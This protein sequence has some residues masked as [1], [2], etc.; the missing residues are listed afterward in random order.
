MSKIALLLAACLALPLAGPVQAHSMD[1][2]KAA[3]ITKLRCDR[4][5]KMAA[6]C[7]PL[8][9]EAHHACD[10]EFLLANP[11]DCSA[12]PAAE[13]PRCEAERSAFKT[14]AD[15]A[16]RAFMVCVRETAKESPLGAH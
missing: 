14:C 6:S 4:H 3:G 11:L 10:R 16:G 13:A 8:K 9:G 1:C 5:E 15:K 7:G 12:L 2:G